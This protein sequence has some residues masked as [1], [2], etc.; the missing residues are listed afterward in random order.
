MLETL[1]YVRESYNMIGLVIIYDGIES[2]YLH[3]V[4]LNAHI[5]YK[6]RYYLKLLKTLIKIPFTPALSQMGIK[7]LTSWCFN[8]ELCYCVH[9]IRRRQAEDLRHA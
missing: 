7:L 1:Y 9:V 8:R 3:A 4:I 5:C 6:N 2:I